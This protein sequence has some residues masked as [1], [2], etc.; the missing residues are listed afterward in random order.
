[1]E[2][3]KH[4]NQVANVQ[5]QYSV[6]AKA[7]T[8]APAKAVTSDPAKAVTSDPKKVEASA[9]AKVDKLTFPDD[10]EYDEEYDEEDGDEDID[11]VYGTIDD[12]ADDSIGVPSNKS[13]SA[14]AQKQYERWAPKKPVQKQ[15]SEEESLRALSETLQDDLNK[16]EAKT[17]A[18]LQ[19]KKSLLKTIERM[20]KEKQQL[21]KEKQQLQKE[22]QQLENDFSE[23]KI[24]YDSIVENCEKY[25]KSKE[26]RSKE[27]HEGDTHRSVGRGTKR[28]VADEIDDKWNKK[29]R[30]LSLEEFRAMEKS[31]P[32]VKSVV[33]ESTTN[34]PPGVTGIRE[35]NIEYPD[36]RR[37]NIK[38]LTFDSSK[39]QM[40]CF[41]RV[42]LR[43]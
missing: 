8:S 28:D 29:D 2:N 37:D 26:K 20:E 30:I 19:Q 21:Q 12:F 40:D 24:H 13:A 23:L 16:A 43:R 4:Y 17:E 9:P 42:F 15:Q 41:E 18:V 32:D 25:Q 35:E 22:K 34:L 27:K 31:K 10:E 36:G 3:E 1:M 7:M 33:R 6:P 5:T 14:P 39:T 38:Y 11:V